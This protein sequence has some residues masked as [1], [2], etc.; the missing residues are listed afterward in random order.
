M[1]DGLIAL[2]K[3]D[4]RAA[5]LQDFGRPDGFLARQ[6]ERWQA[7]L[8]G[9]R[10]KYRQYSGRE[11]PGL[12]DVADWLRARLPAA[13]P[14]GLLHGDFAFPNVMF[15]HRPP[16]RLA[17]IIDWELATVGDPLL[18]LGT[19]LAHFRDA[20]EPGV[21]PRCAYF[22][23]DGFPT[24][25]ELARHYAEGSG[26]AVEHLDYYMVLAL[27]KAACILEHKVAAAL[28]GL[29]PKATGEMFEALVLD[30]AAEAER[31]ARRSV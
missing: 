19:F 21:T 27:Y 15:H 20:R 4:Y 30:F 24:R 22:A 2:S 9:Y 12:A 7:Q 26:R 14:A 5:G 1:V 28:D 25:Q 11:I 10:T 3:V 16:A 13:P 17:A 23:P 8:D 6:V 29:L 18:D 31:I